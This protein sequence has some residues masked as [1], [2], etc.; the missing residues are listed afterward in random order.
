MDIWLCCFRYTQ[1]YALLVKIQIYSFL[2][3]KTD[4]IFIFSEKAI[5]ITHFARK[6]PSMR[7]ERHY[8]LLDLHEMKKLHPDWTHIL[9]RFLPTK[10]PVLFIFLIKI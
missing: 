3:N 7:H 9:L 5:S 10:E 2:F 6:L 4:Y 1:S 8:L